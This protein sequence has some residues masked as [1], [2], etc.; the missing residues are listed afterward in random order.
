MQRLVS[1]SEA[2]SNSLVGSGASPTKAQPR[3]GDAVTSEA[4]AAA[5]SVPRAN[6]SGW[7]RSRESFT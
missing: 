3:C 4:S 2:A 5:N 1:A 7:A 6:P